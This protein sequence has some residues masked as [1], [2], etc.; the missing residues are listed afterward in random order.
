M[1]H[2]T[3]NT[4]FFFTITAGRKAGFRVG[5]EV[6][7]I[8]DSL[9]GGFYGMKEQDVLKA[10]YSDKDKQ[11]DAARATAVEL[12]DGETVMIDGEAYRVDLLGDYL[13][14]AEFYKV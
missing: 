1:K 5:G 2:L 11:E 7:A 9:G 13:D 6:K 10:V 14:C 4:Q 8:K 12:V 3:A